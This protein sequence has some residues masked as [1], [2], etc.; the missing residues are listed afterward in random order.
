MNST[1]VKSR[2]AEQRWCWLYHRAKERRKDRLC[3][4]ATKGRVHWERPGITKP[5][6]RPR[7]DLILTHEMQ[8]GRF[9]EALYWDFVSI[10]PGPVLSSRL[11]F[12][13]LSKQAVPF[14]LSLIRSSV[15]LYLLCQQKLTATALVNDSS[16]FQ[17]VRP[18]GQYFLLIYFFQG[19]IWQSY[20]PLCPT[21]TLFSQLHLLLIPNFSSLPSLIM[22]M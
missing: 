5:V 7:S 2:E 6:L 17:T 4:W 1:L 18:N 14:S 9:W 11:S 8:R 13:K 22:M 21:N 19:S 12:L 16:N 15:H 20:L 3:E 10:N